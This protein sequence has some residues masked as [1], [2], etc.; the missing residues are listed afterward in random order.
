MDNIVIK[1]EET[2]E[3]VDNLEERK[4]KAE[5]DTKKKLYEINKDKLISAWGD[6]RYKFQAKRKILPNEKCHCGSNKKY[7]KCHMLPDS[8]RDEST[9]VKSEPKKEEESCG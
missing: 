8:W 4:K 9:D 1:S 3:K 6:K 5:D 7:K 2:K